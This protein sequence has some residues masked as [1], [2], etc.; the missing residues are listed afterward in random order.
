MRGS[1]ADVV[2]PDDYVDAFKTF[3]TFEDSMYGLPFDGESTA[4]FYRTDLIPTPPRTWS[5]W[6]AVMAKLRRE[7]PSRDFYPIVMPTNEWP[8]S[9]MPR[10]TRTS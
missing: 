2:D 8:N 5:E 4:L 10:L 1:V 9:R 6:N 7:N 3:T